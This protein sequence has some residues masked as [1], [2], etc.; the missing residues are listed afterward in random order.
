MNTRRARHTFLKC[1]QNQKWILLPKTFYYLLDKFKII[2]SADPNGI[3]IYDIE[4]DHIAYNNPQS[5]DLLGY[6]PE[7]LKSI[8]DVIKTRVHSDD[9]WKMDKGISEIHNL[10]DYETNEVEIRILNHMG[11]WIWAHIYLVPFTRNADGGLTQALVVM[12]EVTERIMAEKEMYLQF[13]EIFRTNET[14]TETTNEL[15]RS[16]DALR[17]AN[18]QLNILNTITHHDAMNQLT[19]IQGFANM[20]E[21][22]DL[23]PKYV[24][25]MK[26]INKS[27]QAIQEQLEFVKIYKDIG[28]KAPTWQNL[29]EC[30][31]NARKTLTLKGMEF[32]E[33]DLDVWVLADPMFPKV[34]YNLIENAVRHSGR[35]TLLTISSQETGNMLRIVFQDNGSG[36]TPE[37]KVHLFERGFGK[38]TGL[39]LFLIREILKISN[40]QIVE[41][42]EPGRGAR[43][44]ITL[45]SGSWRNK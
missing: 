11:Q 38:H 17:K 5:A 6:L 28:V 37:D 12:Q 26:K 35:A 42:S 34:V 30:V 43:F 33:M 3:L 19:V 13:D 31:Q 20:L 40:T 7:D 14:L 9:V 23:P 41:N 24:D 45:P 15:R 2:L 18:D 44:E 29:N 8:S 21:E 4:N 16:E 36:I 32:Q 27:A 39:G 1:Y 25:Y 22:A 10:K